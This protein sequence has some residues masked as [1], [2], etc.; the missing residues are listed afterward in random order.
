MRYLLLLT[1]LATLLCGSCCGFEN[2]DN[3]EGP[4]LTDQNAAAS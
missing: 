2:D 3:L 4:L 1:L